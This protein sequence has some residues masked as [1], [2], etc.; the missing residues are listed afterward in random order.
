M[1]GIPPSVWV[2]S[3]LFR[4]PSEI[5]EGGRYLELSFKCGLP[6]PFPLSLY[7]GVQETYFPG[8][9]LTDMR[10]CTEIWKLLG[11]ND[12]FFPF[13]WMKRDIWT[14]YFSDEFTYLAPF[15]ATSLCKWSAAIQISKMA[16][17]VGAFSYF[18]SYVLVFFKLCCDCACSDFF[19]FTF[20]YQY[21]YSFLNFRII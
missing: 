19:Y 12:C 13:E 17:M 16:D 11:V 18:T 10:W 15:T 21:F 1:S 14:S 20:W 7:R 2:K 5:S 9:G 4:D 3:R 8:L 6:L